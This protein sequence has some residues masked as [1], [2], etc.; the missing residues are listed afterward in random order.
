MPSVARLL[1]LALLAACVLTVIPEARGGRTHTVAMR[2]M[3]FTPASLT[4]RKGDVIQWVNDDL[5]PH[6]ATSAEGG[7]DSGPV[8]PGDR[9]TWTVGARGTVSYVCALHPAMTAR[10]QVQ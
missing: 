5:V 7:F 8:A 10:L 1:A 3:Q 4:V 2:Q 6:T 9:W